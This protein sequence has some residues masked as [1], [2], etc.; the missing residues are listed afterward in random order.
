MSSQENEI[1][2]LEK[3]DPAQDTFIDN[4]RETHR[5]LHMVEQSLVMQRGSFDT[6]PDPLLKSAHLQLQALV[7]RSPPTPGLA[8]LL[9]LF[10][11]RLI[12]ADIRQFV[13]QAKQQR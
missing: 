2:V 12:D 10:E 4:A 11:R 9:D 13:N 5:Q 8:R 6:I 3:R 1:V 7:R